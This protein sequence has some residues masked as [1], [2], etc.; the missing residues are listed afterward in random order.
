MLRIKELHDQVENQAGLLGDQAHEL[1]SWNRTL[2]ERVRKQVDE[3][4]RVSR[5]KRFLS[6]QIAEAIIASDA[7]ST[8][9][10]HRRQIAVLFCD[11]RG[12]TA[13][14]DGVEPEEVMS[15]LHDYHQTVG[16]LI[17]AF[18]GT[19]G[20][21]AGDGLMVFFGDPIPR[22][23]AADRSVRPALAMRDRMSARV[24][25]WRKLGHDLGFGVG[26]ALGYATLGRMGFQG[27]YDYGAI[28]SVVNLASRLCAEAA[29]GHILV[30][31]RLYATI[32]GLVEVETVG[33]LALKGIVRPVAAYNV[34]RLVNETVTSPT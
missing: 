14:A 18:E 26:M 31:Q 28:G 9:E 22:D 13:F 17:D 4:E 16:E 29:D 7:E 2:E 33:E 23:D 20:P 27:R 32:E 3:L 6:P 1:A 19:Y 30:N 8:L 10:V 25:A 12:F 24:A 5:L 15:V 21:F 34:I 11:L